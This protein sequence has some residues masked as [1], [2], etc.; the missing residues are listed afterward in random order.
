M[1]L[2]NATTALEFVRRTGRLM[3]DDRRTEYAQAVVNWIAD[4][5]DRDAALS[6]LTLALESG[7]GT[8]KDHSALR[9]ADDLYTLAQILTQNVG[10][11]FASRSSGP[12]KSK[13]Q[14]VAPRGKATRRK[15]GSA[16][17]P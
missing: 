7:R 13:S 9:L 12:E 8:G 15:K 17:K 2:E 16:T 3:S 14:R 4:K 1:S 11:T 10:N 6:C 5:E